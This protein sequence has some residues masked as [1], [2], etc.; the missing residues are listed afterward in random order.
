M[1]RVSRG[2]SETW[3]LR[4]MLDLWLV[5]HG[6]SLGNLDGTEADTGL[7]VR[8]RTQAGAL[9][10]ALAGQTFDR[11]LSSPLQRARETAAIAVPG[12]AIEIEPRLLE[13]VARPERFFDA[14]TLTL[15]QLEALARSMSDEPA[16]ETGKQ[17][18]ARVRAW[19]TQLP[20]A[21]RM[22]AFTHAGV[23]REVLWALLPGAARVQGIGHAA[24]TRVCVAPGANRIVVLDDRRHTDAIR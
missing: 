18:M 3:Y 10:G 20:L 6:E 22:L 19:V 4:S 21:G 14:S 13:L 7:S 23:V 17:F 5:R 16:F 11:V 2:S 15:T 12:H 1:E 24:I 9:A 8:G